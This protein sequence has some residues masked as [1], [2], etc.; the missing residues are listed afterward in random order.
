MGAVQSPLLCRALLD[1][2]IGEEAFDPEGKEEIG[3]KLAA[4]VRN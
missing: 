3:S 2:Y 4:I 1:L